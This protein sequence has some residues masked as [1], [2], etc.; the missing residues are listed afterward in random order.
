VKPFPEQHDLIS[1]FECEPTVL[2]PGVVWAYNRLEFRTIRGRDEFWA[3]IESGETFRLT[4]RRDGEEVVKLDLDRV[5]RFD[6]ELSPKH[7]VLK[8]TFRPTAVA[9]L[10]FQ[11]KPRPHLSWGVLPEGIGV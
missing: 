8:V 10:V 5:Q 4:W 2:D 3:V 7:E 9:E 1:F 11:L 6:V